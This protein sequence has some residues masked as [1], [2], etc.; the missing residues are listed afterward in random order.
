MKRILILTVGGSHEPI[1]ESIEHNN[2]DYVFFLCS[3]D[4]GSTK[5]SYVQVVGDGKVLTSSFEV[6][7]PDLPNIVTLTGLH[8]DGFEIRRIA[9]IDDLPDCYRGAATAIQ[10]AHTRFEHA[11]IFADYT[12]GTK[13]M[14]AGLVAAALDDNECSLTMVTGKRK[15]LK[16]VVDRTSLVRTV[17]IADLQL[18]RRV[19]IAEELLARYDYAAARE[20]IEEASKLC[21]HDESFQQLTEFASLC[22]G[23]DAWDRFDH[24]TAKAC[25]IGLSKGRCGK[26]RAFLDVMLEKRGHGFEMVEDILLNAARRAAQHR[27]D[28]AAGRLYR[29]TEMTAQIWLEEKYGIETGNVDLDK[30]PENTRP[31]LEEDSD[32]KGRIRIGLIKAWDLISEMPDDSVGKKFQTFRPELLKFL[33]V[34][35][36][37][38]L[39]HGIQPV[40][41]R[42]FRLHSDAVSSFIGEVI[43]LAID[44]LKKK[45]KIPATQFPTE[46]G[47][48]PAVG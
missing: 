6:D 48:T 1:V 38:L 16:K 24:R 40:G 33:S 10:D 14:T 9:K 42:Q 44:G 31:S 21:R 5:G 29:A 45:R 43:D 47:Y 32:D 20:V 11:T 39:A 28:D 37:S 18:L 46:F 34:R 2:P 22:R 30:V 3:D 36:E 27:Y 19:K 8:A 25:L 13:S 4:I 41:E 7:S 35:N 17:Q 26:Q 12:G 15:D 23:F